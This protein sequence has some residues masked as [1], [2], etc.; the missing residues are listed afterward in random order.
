LLLSA[1]HFILR[2]SR[3]GHGAGRFKKPFKLHPPVPL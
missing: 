2:M 1:P 3:G